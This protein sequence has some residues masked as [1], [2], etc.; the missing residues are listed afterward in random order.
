MSDDGNQ[1]PGTTWWVGPFPEGMRAYV[2]TVEGDRILIAAGEVDDWESIEVTRH[3]ARMIA[4]RINECL[5]A[6]VK[7]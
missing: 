7:R 2:R 4:K 6:T 1:A 5:D 3:T